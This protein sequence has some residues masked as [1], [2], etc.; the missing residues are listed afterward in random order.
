MIYLIL[1]IL[2]SSAVAVLMRLS[3]RFSKNGMTMLASNYVMCTVAAGFLAGWPLIPEGEGLAF[4]VGAGVVSGVLYLLGFVLLRWNMS[5]NGVVLP[6]TFQKLGVMLPTLAAITIFRETPEVQQ[7]IGIAIA[8]A[9]IIVMQEKRETTGD[10]NLPGLLAL[11]L[12][13][14]GCDLMSKV[15]EHWGNA[16]HNDHFLF[17]TFATALVLCVVLCIVQKQKVALGDVLCGLAI[18]VPNYMS[19]RFL[20]MSLVDLKDNAAVVYPT[21]SAGTIIVVALVGVLAFREKLS[22]RKLIALG[23]ILAALVLLN[24]KLKGAA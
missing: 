2:S 10:S 7:F 22:R 4:T 24:L 8:A 12:V 18:G 9:A 21:F 6:A 1:A 16:L 23:M 20:L 13:C 19:A 5:R 3:G 14:G 11:L 15:F 17:F